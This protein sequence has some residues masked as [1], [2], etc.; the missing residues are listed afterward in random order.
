MYPAF[1]HPAG[2]K[3][4]KST[5]GY[6]AM[7]P[8]ATFLSKEQAKVWAVLYYAPFL[9]SFH[10]IEAQPSGLITEYILY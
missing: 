3:N 5:P 8:S 4:L 6:P 10:N 9:A 2:T 7:K 1:Q